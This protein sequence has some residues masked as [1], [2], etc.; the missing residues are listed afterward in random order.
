[1]K[2]NEHITNDGGRLNDGDSGRRL[3]SV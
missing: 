3:P 1:M 2:Q